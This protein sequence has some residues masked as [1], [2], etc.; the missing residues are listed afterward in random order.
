M[1]GPGAVLDDRYELVRSLATGGMGEIYLA[2]TRST[3]GFGKLVAI[4]VLLP[5]LSSNPAFV[6]MFLDEARNIAKLRHKNIVQI[7]EIAEAAG[8]YYMVMEYIPGQNLRELLGDASI[9]DRPLFDPRLGAEVFAE[10]AEALAVIHTAG[11]V[12]RD[13]SPN[14]IMIGDEGLAK[15]IDFGV[16]RALGT[17]SLT[18]P[19]TLKG[20]F[21]YMAPEYIKGA[22][23]DHRVDLFSLGV[24]MWETFARKRLFRGDSAAEQLHQ[25]L[26]SE[27]EPLDRVIPGFPAALSDIVMHALS[28][29]PDRRIASGR[30]LAEQ[31]RGVAQMLP[32][33]ADPSLRRWLERRVGSRIDERRH[34][35]HEFMNREHTP[36]GPQ[37][38]SDAVP[39]LSRPSIITPVPAMQSG[40]THVP[41]TSGFTSVPSMGSASSVRRSTKFGAGF[42]PASHTTIRKS[43]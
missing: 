33:A 17:A 1:I 41:R 18:N 9:P 13:L 14:N 15:V 10:L 38:A 4:K 39:R 16:A 5:N 8:H 21:T 26:E 25:V 3:S 22:K 19:G 27:V 32:T 28:R 29:D 24:V 35:A 43:V 40:P 20:K 6:Q 36:T 2:R 12:H 11:L 23:Y 30:T 31:L 34:Q 42:S 7:Y 37:L